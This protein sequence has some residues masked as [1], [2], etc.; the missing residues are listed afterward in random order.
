MNSKLLAKTMK[1][2]LKYIANSH[3]ADWEIGGCSFQSTWNQYVS[4]SVKS[5]NQRNYYDE[6]MGYWRHQEG[7]RQ[8]WFGAS[9][10]SY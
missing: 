6:T 1:K 9:Q 10:I 3:P 7:M 8:P 5:D 2:I 4:S